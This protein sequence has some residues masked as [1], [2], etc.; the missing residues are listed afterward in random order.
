M[1]QRIK[2]VQEMTEGGIGAD[3]VFEA[4]AASQVLIESLA[5]SIYSIHRLDVKKVKEITYVRMTECIV[6][7][8]GAIPA[9]KYIGLFKNSR[10]FLIN[11]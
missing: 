3:V 10:S 7:A 8:T 1:E 2:I 6:E 4:A 5:I 9:I 11:Y